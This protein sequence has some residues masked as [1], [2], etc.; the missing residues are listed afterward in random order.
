MIK[1][2]KLEQP[3]EIVSEIKRSA[4]HPTWEELSRLF[5]DKYSMDNQ[6]EP[7]LPDE[8]MY[9]LEYGNRVVQVKLFS[10][11]ESETTELFAMA[12]LQIQSDREPQKHQTTLLFQGI[13]EK[14]QNIAKEKQQ[15][16]NYTFYTTNQN[17]AIWAVTKG[18]DIFSWND[19]TDVKI[20]SDNEQDY[21]FMPISEYTSL[22]EKEREMLDVEI[23]CAAQIKP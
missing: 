23:I 9:V 19:S 4:H 10:E 12:H 21:K 15:P 7:D 1:P 8:N 22:I 17:M 20:K 3:Q 14:L 2:D 18:N 6:P 13:K 16:I 11:E 5:P